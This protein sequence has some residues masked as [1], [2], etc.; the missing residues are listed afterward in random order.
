MFNLSSLTLND[1]TSS[2]MRDG[3][4][5]GLGLS[6]ISPV[7]FAFVWEFDILGVV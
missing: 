4:A 1:R 7:M 2:G 5:P 3:F 6:I